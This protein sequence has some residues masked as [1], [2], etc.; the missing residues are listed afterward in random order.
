M[1]REA[2]GSGSG[3][4][5]GSGGAGGRGYWPRALSMDEQQDYLG[6]ASGGVP[7]SPVSGGSP[8]K[9]LG[10]FTWGEAA[11]IDKGSGLTWRRCPY[12]FFR[13]SW[14]WQPLLVSPLA[15]P[16]WLNQRRRRG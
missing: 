15:L 12:Y 13:L 3:V 2:P 8:P 6:S 5:F 14:C 1:R 16:R 10:Q 11:R 4:G 7:E 9:S